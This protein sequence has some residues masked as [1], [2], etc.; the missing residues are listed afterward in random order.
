MDEHKVLTK[1]VYLLVHAD[2]QVDQKERV[3]CQN[4]V[5][6]EKMEEIRFDALLSELKGSCPIELT[7]KCIEELKELGKETQERFM[8]W[9]FL[10]ANA[11]G[12]MDNAEWDL[13]FKIY[14]KGLQLKNGPIMEQQ[15]ELWSAIHKRKPMAA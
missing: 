9:A 10:L 1:L 15:Q 4:L 3:M 6:H 13:I 7:R 8:A 12:I 2:G 14:H 5:L 11:D